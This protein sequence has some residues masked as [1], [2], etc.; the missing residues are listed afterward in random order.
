MDFNTLLYRLG[1]NPSNFVNQLVEPIRTAD[2]FIYEV[3]QK[4]DER[5]CPHCGSQDSTIND[6]DYVEI[7]CSETD[8]IKDILRIKKVRFKCKGCGKTYTP[9]IQGIER[10][11]KTSGQTLEMIIK[12]FTKTLTFS[13]IAERY[14]LTKNRVI[15]IFDEK[16]RHVPRRTLP[17]VLCID[18]IRFHEDPTQ[19]YCCV[20]YDF[21]QRE[22]VD[23]VKNR[24]LAYLDEYFSDI[25]Q[26]ERNNVRIF[27]S[28]M[29][30]GY[31]TIHKKYF[32]KA[33]HIVDLF[34]VITQLT[35]AV[36]RIR[37]TTMNR[38]PKDN[39]T[40]RFM[41]S[42]WKLF[43]C[44]KEKIPNRFYTSKNTGEV[45]H[46]DD[47]VFQSIKQNQDLLEAYN[48]LQDLYHYNEKYSFAEAVDFI[49]YISLRLRQSPNPLLNSVGDTYLKWMYEIANGLSR[50]QNNIRYTNSIAESINNHLKTIIKAAYGYRNFERFRKRALMII[51]F[52]KDLASARPIDHV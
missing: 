11:A 50:S 28:D 15:Q 30:D 37:V 52:K 41:K 34:H 44:R 35:R 3:E 8:H 24:R 51:T 27:I 4:K 32:P 10:Y 39:L 23:I 31:A 13:Q 5:S 33:L 2:G 21:R 18:E 36:N 25:P 17:S 29:Y 6:Y 12:D 16:I 43:L 14:G 7:N 48:C 22:I 45:F 26:K 19:K 20:L 9:A 49:S 47:M 40:Y 1:V 38:L 46:F 42:H